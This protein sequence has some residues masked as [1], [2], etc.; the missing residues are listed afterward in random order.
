M[1]LDRQCTSVT[2]K[3]FQTERERGT[4]WMQ[5]AISGVLMEIWFT[6]K[7]VLPERKL[8]RSKCNFPIPLRYIDVHRKTKTSLDV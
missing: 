8:H 6:K 3:I 7:H 4:Q 5:G 2:K 1:Y